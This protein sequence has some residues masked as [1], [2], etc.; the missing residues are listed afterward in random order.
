MLLKN[1]NRRRL[2][3]IL[4][5]AAA[6]VGS[7]IAI[8]YVFYLMQNV[9]YLYGAAGGMATMINSYN[10]TASQGQLAIVSASNTLKVLMRTVDIMLVVS[11]FSFAMSVLWFFMKSYSK[12]SKTLLAFDSFIF[13]LLAI[14]LQ[15]E[16]V[17]GFKIPILGILYLGGILPLAG[18][19]YSI[20]ISGSHARRRSAAQISIDPKKPFTNMSIITNKLMKKL[21]GDIK[22]LDMHFDERALSNLGRLVDASKSSY[23]SILVATGKER[24]DSKLKRHL[25]DFEKEMKNNG[26]H[27]EIRIMADEDFA[28]QHERFIM[29]DYAAY[30]IPPFNIINKKSEHIVSIKYAG[31]KNRFEKIWSRAVKP[32]NS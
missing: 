27:F 23:R 28:A 20:A 30:K 8:L 29:D 24:F 2:E 15:I 5:P 17:A 22:I 4:L 19:M 32:S 6:L 14:V 10:I 25:D 13:L 9:A 1:I 16:T 18:S 12:L 7:F 11:I 31:A 3:S 26:V 21:S